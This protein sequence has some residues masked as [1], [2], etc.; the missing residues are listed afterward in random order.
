MKRVCLGR[1]LLHAIS[2][3]QLHGY[4]P[5]KFWESYLEAP[6]AWFDLGRLAMGVTLQ[7]VDGG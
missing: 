2:G 5:R 6:G 3:L 7:L 1:L 4:E